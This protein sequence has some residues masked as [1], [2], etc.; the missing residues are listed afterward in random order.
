M[1]QE[2]NLISP[3]T[4]YVYLTGIMLFFRAITFTGISIF[5]GG[6]VKNCS[7]QQKR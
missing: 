5:P 6:E 4:L 1:N 2:P 3:F 7:L